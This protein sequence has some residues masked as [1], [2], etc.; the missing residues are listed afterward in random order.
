MPSDHIYVEDVEAIVDAPE[1]P[2]AP[3]ITFS[4]PGLADL[5]SMWSELSKL[6]WDI[7][8]LPPHPDPE[9]DW[10][11]ADGSRVQVLPYRVDDFEI[12]ATTWPRHLVADRGLKTVNLLRR[13]GVDLD[14]PISYLDFLRRT[15]L[16]VMKDPSRN[17]PTP[18]PTRVPE[19][20]FLSEQ[21]FAALVD[22]EAIEVFETAVGPG[23]TNLYWA[24]SDQS[25]GELGRT[26][27]RTQMLSSVAMGW[28]LAS[29]IEAPEAIR[30]Q[31]RIL[32]FIVR[33]MGDGTAMLEQLEESIGDA[34]ASLMMRP[35]ERTGALGNSLLIIAVVPAERFSEIGQALISNFPDAV[36]RGRRYTAASDQA[37]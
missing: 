31:D 5:S 20:L 29:R 27:D 33:D 19:T 37:A 36:G 3:K 24:E 13:I 10:N 6:G 25:I 34:Y 8:E 16:Q 14:V 17:N 7:P 35:I 18:K 22:D 23:Q 15:Q 26:K 21:P 1:G 11:A 4:F 12:T 9:I 2:R 30:G 28:E 32:R